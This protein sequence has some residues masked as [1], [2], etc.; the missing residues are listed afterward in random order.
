MSGETMDTS[1]LRPVMA[2]MGEFSAGKSTLANLLLGEGHSPVK[3]TATQL[4]PVWF[5]YGDESPYAVGLDGSE[6]P[7]AIEDLEQ[8]SVETTAHVRI[9]LKAEI[10]EL[11][12]LIDM[13]GNSDPN[14]SAEVWRRAVQHVD[15]VIWCSHANQAWRQSEA[16]VWEEMPD[17]LYPNSILLLTRFD[18]ILGDSNRNRVL[19]RVRAEAEDGFAG[20]YPISLTDA[21]SAGENRNQWEASG[22]EDFIG[23][24]LEIVISGI[25]TPAPEPEADPDPVEPVSV[26][27]RRVARS[28][29]EP[30]A[31]TRLPSDR[32]AV[33]TSV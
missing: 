5:S 21:L 25:D 9:F 33:E 11:M 4:P 28:S 18:K 26:M 3:V 32:P 14:M 22:A 1:K 23:A 30:P 29:G 10:L 16:A 12:D 31:R 2:L 7:L 19:R 15:G 6:T 20:I 8:V 27:P 24:L 13:P 17:H